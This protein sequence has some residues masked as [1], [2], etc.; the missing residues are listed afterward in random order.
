M[1]TL[2]KVY[3]CV[4]E[5]SFWPTVFPELEALGYSVSQLEEKSVPAALSGLGPG[6]MLFLSLPEGFPGS[7]S[8]AWAKALAQHQEKGGGWV[9]LV[10][11]GDEPDDGEMAFLEAGADDF[12]GWPMRPKALRACLRARVKALRR[13]D[14]R[15]EECE[16]YM[17]FFEKS[18][19]PLY[20]FDLETFGFLAVNEPALAQYGYT[21]E[22]FMQ[23]RV[24]D[25][26]P[27]SDLEKFR[28]A[29]RKMKNGFEKLDGVWRHRTRDGRMILVEIARHR[30]RLKGRDALL[31]LPMDVTR[32]EEINREREEAFEELAVQR[33]LLAIAGK[34]ARLGGWL[35]RLSDGALICSDELRHLFG[36]SGENA[37]PTRE[38]FFG[39]FQETLRKQLNDCWDCCTREGENFAIE[40]WCI[41]ADKKRS[42][43]NIT[44]Q[45]IRDEAGAIM[46]IQGAVQDI[47]EYNQVVRG[48]RASE[49][50]FR[51]LAGAASDA[52]WDWNLEDGTL[53][54]NEGFTNLFGHI[55]DDLHEAL[56]QWSE[57]IH[58]ED[59]D[60]VLA[61]IK[62]SLQGDQVNWS[63]EY[64][65]LKANGEYAY[66]ADR[67]DIVRD[68]RGQA[69]RMVGGM[70]DLTARKRQEEQV[71][72][73]QRLESIGTLAGGIAHDFNNILAPIVLSAGIIRA[74]DAE[75]QNE[76]LIK[77]IEQSAER[78]SELVK[79]ILSFTRIEE[80]QKADFS[81]VRLI[82]DVADSLQNLFGPRYPVEL[83]LDSELD[84]VHG[85]AEQ[86]RQA[87]M[88]LCL[89]ARDAMPEGGEITI[90]AAN[91]HLKGDE[92]MLFS[93]TVPG[94]Y[95]C[96]EICD[97]GRGI[98]PA[99]H[100]RIFEPF[101]TTKE[102]GRGTGLGLSTTLGIIK[103]HKGLIKLQSDPSGGSCFSLYFPAHRER[104]SSR[105]RTA[106][107]SA[108]ARRKGPILVVDDE[109][110]ILEITEQALS[111]L[112]H[113][114]IT[115]TNGEEA[116]DRY[117]EQNG[118]VALVV[119]D[120]MMPKMDG[121]SLIKALRE[122]DP[123]IKVIAASGYTAEKTR[124]ELGHV[125][126]QAFLAKPFRMSVLHDKINE[127]LSDS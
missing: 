34:M 123:E 20:V 61:G 28:Q 35:Y 62:Q 31:V 111:A 98:P 33:N 29:M 64:R 12:W 51:L 115:A 126:V 85:E 86:L 110:A 74:R 120:M 68:D 102:M 90:R 67:G 77:T 100:E 124:V 99:L 48:L 78:G 114:V 42:W 69:V 59:R 71:R 13:E 36:W 5:E 103:A 96:L 93:R 39:L 15:R 94:D 65:F 22:E 52:I 45:P 72:R 54:W 49:E 101:F 2:K 30:I 108:S 14:S 18:P 81:P 105:P 32:R 88:N 4:R 91:V 84:W 127:I 95:V 46:A 79:Q 27:V 11:R 3:V 17:L 9:C 73:A 125:E 37:A 43:V 92:G 47:T 60:A 63:A 97:E 76:K 53:W 107:K 1:T 104:S 44:G 21:R 8:V 19:H 24:D 50:R 26:R 40:G 109:T 7:S 106:K 118:S 57:R 16:Q 75:G 25:L 41:N 87:L 6:E 23:L 58:A 10:G 82:E 122:E 66:V 56:D 112:G 116:M 83:F 117:R 55:Q 113:E 119:T 38:T 80:G 70:I 121:A 89:N